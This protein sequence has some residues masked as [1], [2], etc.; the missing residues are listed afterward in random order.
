MEP[1]I[2]RNAT[3]NLTRSTPH[4]TF[5]TRA[6]SIGNHS[7]IRGG[8]GL[9]FWIIAGFFRG[10]VATNITLLKHTTKFYIVLKFHVWPMPTRG[11]CNSKVTLCQ[12]VPAGSPIIG[13]AP[14]IGN[15]CTI[16]FTTPIMIAGFLTGCITTN[17]SAPAKNAIIWVW[18]CGD[19]MKGQNLVT[20]EPSFGRNTTQNFTHST[21]HCTFPAR[22]A[23]IGNCSA[24][25]VGLTVVIII[26]AGFVYVW[27]EQ[28]SV[29]QPRML[30]SRSV[31]SRKEVY[32]KFMSDEWTL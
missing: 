26:I 19:K 10:C 4:C 24:I 20:M 32:H 31:W 1:S 6:A 5:P 21:P 13:R 15:L 7:A 22:A 30:L 28:I 23:S 27:S 16:Q 25:V 8:V 17:I 11:K 12:I 2:G 3:Q 9:T 18:L 14:S 29:H